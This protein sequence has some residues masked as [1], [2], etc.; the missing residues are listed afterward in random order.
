MRGTN[1][2][3]SGQGNRFSIYHKCMK[4]P[5]TTKFETNG[6]YYVCQRVCFC[7]LLFLHESAFKIIK[8]K[9]KLPNKEKFSKDALRST[10]G[11][12]NKGKER[13]IRDS[14]KVIMT[15]PEEGAVNALLLEKKSVK[16]H[17]GKH[18]GDETY[19]LAA[20]LKK[21]LHAD[22]AKNTWIPGLSI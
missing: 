22:N 3:D 13:T 18:I 6:A 1:L 4:I 12:M 20:E 2:S 16:Q 5:I 21:F 11:K 10:V 8:D 7:L 14:W 19:F 15:G 9:R 17:E